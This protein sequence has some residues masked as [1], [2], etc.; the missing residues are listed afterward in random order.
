[1]TLAL[2]AN[3]TEE[4]INNND[5]GIRNISNLLLSYYKNTGFEDPEGEILIFS[6]IMK[7]ALVQYLT[8]PELYPA[9]Y[10]EQKIITYFEKTFSNKVQP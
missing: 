9:E 4:I 2:Q 6:C 3:I 7:G 5:L 1:M 10:V 8:T